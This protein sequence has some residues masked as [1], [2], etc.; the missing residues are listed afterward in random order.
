MNESPGEDNFAR[1][2]YAE[3]CIIARPKFHIYIVFSV[4]VFISPVDIIV[5]TSVVFFYSNICQ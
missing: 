4:V 5:P 2:M 3:H 1:L